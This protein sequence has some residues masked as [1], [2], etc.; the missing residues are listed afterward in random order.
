MFPN[1]FARGN[2]LLGAAAG[3]V[4]RQRGTPSSPLVDKLAKGNTNR[5]IADILGVSPRR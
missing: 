2:A 4:L 3:R 1:A 5:D